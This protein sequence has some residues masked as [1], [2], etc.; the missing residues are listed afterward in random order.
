M[1][2]NLHVRA[3][4]FTLERVMKSKSVKIATGQ[5]GARHIA[6]IRLSGETEID[7]FKRLA[8]KY[9]IRDLVEMHL[10]TDPPQIKF[11]VKI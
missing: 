6:G 3:T 5:N 10:L 4:I 9:L 2:S 8:K 7:V 1:D 11:D